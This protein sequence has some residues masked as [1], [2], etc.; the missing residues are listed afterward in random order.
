MGSENPD[1]LHAWLLAFCSPEDAYQCIRFGL[2]PRH[3]ESMVHTLCATQPR[4]YS[5]IIDMAKR[6][7][8]RRRVVELAGI[9]NSDPLLTTLSSSSVSGL[10]HH[11]K[12]PASIH[13]RAPSHDTILTSPSRSNS[14]P[15]AFDR[16]WVLDTTGPDDRFCSIG[17]SHSPYR[18]VRADF[19]HRD[20]PMPFTEACDKLSVNLE[21]IGD[22]SSSECIHLTWHYQN[23]KATH[24]ELFWIIDIENEEMCDL[25]IADKPA[26]NEDVQNPQLIEHRK[27]RDQFH[28]F[29][30]THS[31][32]AH[33]SSFHASEQAYTRPTRTTQPGEQSVHDAVESQ[34]SRGHGG[35]LYTSRPTAHHGDDVASSKLQTSRQV[36]LEYSLGRTGGEGT[37]PLND[38]QG[39]TFLAQLSKFYASAH[40]KSPELDR[41]AFQVKFTAVTEDTQ[42]QDSRIYPLAESGFQ[43]RW[44]KILRFIREHQ[45]CKEFEVELLPN[46]ADRLG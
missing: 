27:A 2:S 30:A 36:T 19:L 9:F 38:R 3:I 35:S 26:S 16:G 29:E 28:N 18:F 10:S 5:S 12:G 11:P 34:D 40:R 14:K 44:E 17:K 33:S 4:P 24:G 41:S 20:R 23:S 21:G 6:D 39:E 46:D 31:S 43:R 32:D 8:E 37:L 13:S 1:P 7:M 45:D 42:D 22:V 25:L 15:S